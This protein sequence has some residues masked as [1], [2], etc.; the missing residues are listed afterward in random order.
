MQ[1]I[2]RTPPR[3]KRRHRGTRRWNASL[4]GNRL[5]PIKKLLT[6]DANTL[7]A[8]PTDHPRRRPTLPV[9]RFLLTPEEVS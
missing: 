9:L 6:G 2:T 5:S 4:G 1:E 3:R 7:G 8:L